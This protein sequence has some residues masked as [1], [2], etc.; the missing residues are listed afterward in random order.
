MDASYG[1]WGAMTRRSVMASPRLRALRRRARALAVAGRRAGVADPAEASPRRR[2]AR[3]CGQTDCP[4]R[5][6]SGQ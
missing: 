3:P 6:G 2:A 4:R 1:T 5:G